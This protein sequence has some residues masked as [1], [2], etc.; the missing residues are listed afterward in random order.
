MKQAG[1]LW[2]FAL[3]MPVLAW[4]LLRAMFDLH[5]FGHYPGPTATSST[6][7]PITSAT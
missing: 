7:S 5:G 3:T 2:M 1:R 4:L 6:T